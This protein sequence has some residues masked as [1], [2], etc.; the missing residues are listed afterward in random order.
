MRLYPLVL[1]GLLLAAVPAAAQTPPSP[2]PGA[3]AADPLDV[4]LQR[5]EAAMLKV[6]TLHAVLK[7]TE[8]DPT[9]NASQTYVG[10]AQY[11][12]A[13]AGANTLNLALLEMKLQGKTEI[14][15]KFI[16]TGTYLYQY[17]PAAKE[18]RAY[19]LPRPKPGQ[20]ADDNFLSFLFGMKA[21]EAKRRYELKLVKEKENDKFWIYVDVHPR[22]PG[23]KADFEWARIV[24]S[25]T[26]YLPRQLW[27]KQKTGPEVLWD[28][29]PIRSGVQLNRATFDAPKPEPGWKLVMV[30]KNGAVPPK[31]I[32]SMP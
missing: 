28:V 14:A 27:F 12:K 2:K 19:E 24:L 30:P 17:S 4:Y 7:R 31:V 20:V 18:I 5:W 25:R 11:M 21:E 10:F 13:G 8:K 29:D 16:C 3:Q 23:D 15:E 6:Q 9:F 22:F 1:L 32:R 26:T